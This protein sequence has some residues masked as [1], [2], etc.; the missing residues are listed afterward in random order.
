MKMKSVRGAAALV[1]AA[2]LPLATPARADAVRGVI[3]QT[4]GHI[5]PSCRT[6]VLKRKDNGATISFRIATTNSEDGVMAVTLTALTTG[7]EV[8]IFYTPGVTTGC[9]S[10]PRIEY[11]TLFA[12]GY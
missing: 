4:E 5:S 3:I 10:E 9:G 1:L 8:Q 12:Q 11:I 2:T 6:V 7:R